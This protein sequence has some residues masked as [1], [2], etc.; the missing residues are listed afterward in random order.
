MKKTINPVIIWCN[1]PYQSNWKTCLYT[2]SPV[3]CMSCCNACF[4][5]SNSNQQRN[6]KFLHLENSLMNISGKLGSKWCT[7]KCI[8]CSEEDW[9][10]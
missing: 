3:H 4:C 10:V 9:K 8:S 7:N 6:G 1:C 5:I 2:N